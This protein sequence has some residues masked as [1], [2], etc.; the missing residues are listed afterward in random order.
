MEHLGVDVLTEQAAVVLQERRVV[1]LT[2]WLADVLRM[3]GQSGRGLQVVT[4]ADARLTWPLGLVLGPPPSRWVVRTADGHYDAMTGAVLTWD[5]RSFTAVRDGDSGRLAPAFVETPE[6]FGT[7]LVLAVRMQHPPAQDVVFG[8]AVERACEMLTGAP[9]GGWGT[10]EPANRLWNREELTAFCLGRAPEPTLTVFVGGPGASHPA[11]GTLEVSCAPAGVRESVRFAIGFPPEQEPPAE[12][13]RALA[14][15]LAGEVSL[16]SLFAQRGIGRA[17]LTAVPY[18]T[19]VPGPTGLALGVAGL[20]P[21]GPERAF[22]PPNLT[23]HPIGTEQAP[24][25]W[26]DLGDGRSLDGFQRLGD[27]VRH[28]KLGAPAGAPVAGA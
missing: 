5:G 17:D 3:C 20:R 22:D 8:A 24:A 27:L 2:A 21:I 9:P 18:W 7:Q 11:L 28:L 23:A 6:R 14:G 19:G 10:T 15:E 4:P 26:Y 1:P 12:T 13:V 25:V 16:V